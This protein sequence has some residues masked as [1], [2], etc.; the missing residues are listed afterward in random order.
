MLDQAEI[1]RRIRAA[2]ALADISS[3]DQLAEKTGMSRSTVKDLGTV[4]GRANEG[5]LR[6]I[7][8]A[9]D[10]PYPWF[11]VP[12]VGRAIAREDDEPALVERVEALEQTVATLVRLAGTDAV[13]TPAPPG[14]LGRRLQDREP[15]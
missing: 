9:C 4:R 14:E 11:T 15:G 12:D 6:V 2:M 8:A 10:L 7:A 3:W 1:R 5:H 13:S